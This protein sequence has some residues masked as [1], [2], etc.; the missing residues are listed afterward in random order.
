[1]NEITAF[2]SKK[3]KNNFY[4]AVVWH[5]WSVYL[6]Y[7]MMIEKKST[8]LVFYRCL[9][10]SSLHFD[11]ACSFREINKQV[12][13]QTLSLTEVDLMPVYP[14]LWPP[15]GVEGAKV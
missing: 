4:S 11:S 9:T 13:K 6:Q 12:Y 5:S 3:N 2:F 1:V 10:Y 7:E 8:V 15:D 14:E